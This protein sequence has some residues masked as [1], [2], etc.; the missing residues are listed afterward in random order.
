M[1]FTLSSSV[2]S[3]KLGILAKVI[4]SKN[5]LSILDSFLFSVDGET[6]TVT[7]SDNNNMMKCFIPLTNASGQG[8]FCVSNKLILNA[9]KELA[10]QPLT[11]EV[12]DNSNGIKIVYQNGSYSI[13]G[14]SADEY[15]NMQQIS[16]GYTETQISASALANPSNPCS[17]YSFIHF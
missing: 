4:N 15:P 13:M 2:L 3:N 17:S 7:A 8:A 6:L 11:F 12:D 10:E 1:T 14:Q 9:V 16:D 5:S